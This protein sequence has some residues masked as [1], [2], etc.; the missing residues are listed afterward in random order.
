MTI[1][2]EVVRIEKDHIIVRICS[3]YY[4]ID[5]KT[6][7][8]K[9]VMICPFCKE[10]LKTEEEIVEHIK[11]HNTVVKEI[12]LKLT[13]IQILVLKRLFESLEE[14][15]DRDDYAH[16]LVREFGANLFDLKEENAR[17]VLEVVEREIE[18]LEK[19]LERL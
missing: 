4:R 14:Y 8:K 11:K 17:Q 3:E 13:P 10:I 16:S 6:G 19:V 1:E 5:T 2:P 7:A 18:K 12:K 15:E 9:K